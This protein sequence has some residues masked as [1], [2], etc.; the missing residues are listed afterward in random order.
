M[1]SLSLGIFLYIFGVVTRSDI[2]VTY[3][4]I[5]EKYLCSNISEL[6]RDILVFNR[7]PYYIALFSSGS[8]ISMFL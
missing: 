5:V 8:G 3:W 7:A 1:I 2:W 6:R 4:S